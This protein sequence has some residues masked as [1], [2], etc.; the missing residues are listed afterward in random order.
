[1]LAIIIGTGVVLGG[2]TP[3][4]QAAFR[5]AQPVPT[6][7]EQILQAQEAQQ[8]KPPPQNTGEFGPYLQLGQIRAATME[9]P[10]DQTTALV[11]LEPW[12]SYEST[13]PAF[14][15]ELSTKKSQL[16]AIVLDFFASRTA[17]QL[18]AMGEGEVK[19]Q[20]MELVDQELVLGDISGIFFDAYLFLE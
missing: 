20:L 12:F 16:Q 19:S 2:R 18:K 15:E 5:P 17:S 9:D 4:E 11:I 10:E 14:Q 1:M 3:K 8:E 13:D 7:E 6:V